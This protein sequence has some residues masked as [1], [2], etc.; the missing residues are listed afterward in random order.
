MDVLQMALTYDDVALVPQ[1]NNV[2]SR[3]EPTLETWL[4]K[5]TKIG[6]PLLAANM[7]TVICDELADVLLKHGSIPIFHRYTSF[8]KQEAWCNK[9]GSNCFISC[10][11][12]KYDETHRLLQTGPD[13]GP[14][15]VCIDVAHGHSE[16]MIK[17]IRKIKHDFPTKEVIAGNICTPQGYQDLVN[18][19]ADAVKCGVGAG[20]LGHNTQILMSNGSYKYIRDVMPGDKV[21]NRYGLPVSV[22]SVFSTGIRN[23]IQLNTNN[24]YEP[25]YVTPDHRYLYSNNWYNIWDLD[26][27]STLNSL[28]Y[29]LPESLG[30]IDV[31]YDLGFLFG[32]YLAINIKLRGSTNYNDEHR[33]QFTSAMSDCTNRLIDKNYDAILLDNVSYDFIKT[34]E[35]YYCNNIPYM[36]GIYDGLS[37]FNEKGCPTYWVCCSMLGH[38]TNCH[39]ISKNDWRT[40]YNI[41]VW[42]LEIDCPTHSFIANN[43]IVHNSCCSTRIQTGFGIPMFSTIYDIGQLANKLRVPIIADGGI[44][45]PKDAAIALAAGASTVMMGNLFAK[46]N[47]SAGEKI[48]ID[49]ALFSHYRGQASKEFQV[50]HYGGIKKGTVEEGVSFNTPCSGPAEHLVERFTG[51][52]RSSFTYGGARDIKEFQRKAEFRRVTQDASRESHPRTWQ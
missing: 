5:N 16:E 45:H 12:N 25:T 31:C 20:C 50:D 4:T 41:E 39:I 34:P 42:D 18:A 32:V 21:I 44:V 17:L 19:G 37:K 24:W 2:P 35:K 11:F 38:N 28:K 9:Y 46:T 29:D 43:S 52:I 26:S 33:Q 23:V 7:D 27:V 51:G 15:G 36:R 10:G 40:I 14:K 13:G 49:G 3:L 8:E 1:Y 6:I 22:K 30:N 48:N 47:E